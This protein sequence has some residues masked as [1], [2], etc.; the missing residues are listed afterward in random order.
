[1][2]YPRFSKI[3]KQLTGRPRANLNR[4]CETFGAIILAGGD[5][6]VP[7]ENRMSIL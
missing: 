4:P 7:D 2:G 5:R 3:K 6:K 1:M